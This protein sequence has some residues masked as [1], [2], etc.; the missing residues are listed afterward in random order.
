M[1]SNHSAKPQEIPL[2]KE[3]LSSEKSRGN[4]N[5]KN[6]KK[7]IPVQAHHTNLNEP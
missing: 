1:F 5:V 2:K 7:K 3:L 6:L 4:R